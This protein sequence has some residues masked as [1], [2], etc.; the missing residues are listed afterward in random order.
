MYKRK[1]MAHHLMSQQHMK[2]SDLIKAYYRLCMTEATR[3]EEAKN[4]DEVNEVIRCINYMDQYVDDIKA[5]LIEKNELV[6][7]PEKMKEVIDEKKSLLNAFQ[8]L[9]TRN[10]ELLE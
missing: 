3:I 1:E 5:D 10:M 8:Y 6:T 4:V 7:D 9:L 2:F